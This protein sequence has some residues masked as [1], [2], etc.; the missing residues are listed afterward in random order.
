VVMKLDKENYQYALVTG[1]D[2]DYLWLLARSKT[3]SD[4]TRDA[5]LSF[6]NQ[7]GYD[8]D[9]LIWVDHDPANAN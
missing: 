7:K 6:A 2:R 5:L 1:P 8:T 4:E 9:K 3:I